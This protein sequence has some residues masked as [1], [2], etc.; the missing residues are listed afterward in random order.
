ME[1]ASKIPAGTEG[2]RGTILPVIN[3]FRSKC[4]FSCKEDIRMQLTLEFKKKRG[5][6]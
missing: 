5:I 3:G 6:G 4:C 1:S 2:T